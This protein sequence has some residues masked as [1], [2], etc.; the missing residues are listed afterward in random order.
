MW[1]CKVSEIWD[2]YGEQGHAPDASTIYSSTR[3]L[4]VEVFYFRPADI[5]LDDVT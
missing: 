1:I 4:Y 5:I 3:H 2:I